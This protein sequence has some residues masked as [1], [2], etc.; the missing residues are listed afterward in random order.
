MK[1][2]LLWSILFLAAFVST[3]GAQQRSSTPSEKSD[4]SSAVGKPYSF[5]L[6]G[7]DGKIYDSTEMRGEVLVAS[8]GATWCAPCAWELAAIEELKQEYKNKPVRFLWISIEDEKRT[9]NAL[10]RYYAKSQRLTIPVLR[11]ADGQAFMQFST[12]VR[13]PL[14]VF[15]DRQGRFNA[16]SHRGMSQD[17][18]EYKQL[19]RSRVDA[20]LKEETKTDAGAAATK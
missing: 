13:I 14:V 1:K 19:V 3:A 7:I 2:Q 16:P 9:S 11:D 15:F 12:S 18:M 10:L 8:F 20:L 5:K 4:E 17:M 6:K